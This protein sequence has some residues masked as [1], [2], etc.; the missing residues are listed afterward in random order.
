MLSHLPSAHCTEG[1]RLLA[2]IENI[3]LQHAAS[4]MTSFSASANVSGYLSRSRRNLIQP[5]GYADDG[6]RAPAPATARSGEQSCQQSPLSAS[7]NSFH[8]PTATGEMP[9]L[10]EPSAMSVRRLRQASSSEVTP[11]VA[12]PAPSECVVQ[13]IDT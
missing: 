2:Q 7:L 13:R 6:Q 8:G 4:T 9:P 10:S 11:Y 12:S 5:T 1:A 3:S